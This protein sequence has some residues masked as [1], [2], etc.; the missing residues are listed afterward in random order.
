[1]RRALTAVVIMGL[2]TTACGAGT[3]TKDAA[4]SVRRAGDVAKALGRDNSDLAAFV[5]QAEKAQKATFRAE[6]TLRRGSD[7]A[8]R[9]VLEQK[10]PKSKYVQIDEHGKATT[11]IND[12]VDTFTCVE[13][14]AGTTCV[15][16]NGEGGAESSVAGLATIFNPAAILV[17]LRA[18]APLAGVKI[19]VTSSTRSIAAQQVACV[20][21]TDHSGAVADVKTYCTTRDGV[22]ALMEEKDQTTTLSDYTTSVPD[23]DFAVTGRVVS[24]PSGLYAPGSTSAGPGGGPTG[25]TTAP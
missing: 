18:Y 25:T 15:K 8:T 11:I 16:G 13:V 7:P 19:E 12:G 3:K 1:M 10:P 17:A 6:Y 9:M 22:F 21:V 14:D 23:S 4:R 2:L 24:D 5:A 20:T